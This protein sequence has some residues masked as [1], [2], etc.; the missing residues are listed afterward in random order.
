MSFFFFL[1]AG[2][3]ADDVTGVWKPA[4]ITLAVSLAVVLVGLLMAFL[5]RR[6]PKASNSRAGDYVPPRQY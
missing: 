4:V 2:I 5:G 1:I 6:N 3:S